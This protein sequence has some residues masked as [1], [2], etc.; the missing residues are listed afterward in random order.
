MFPLDAILNIGG[1]ILDKV[2]P[3]PAQAEQAKL[4]LLEM[5]QNGELAQIAADTAEQQELTKRQQADMMSDSWLSKNIRPMTLLFILGGYFIFAMMSAFDLDTNKA[6]VELLGQWGMLI[7]SFYFGGRTLEKIMDMK[8][9][10]KDA[11]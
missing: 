4:K 10:E 2:F 8:A 6:Y 1:K 11:K 7:M 5:Q 3:D 9:K